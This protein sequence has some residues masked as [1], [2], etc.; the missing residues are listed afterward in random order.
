MSSPSNLYAEKVF[1]EQPIALWALDETVD[2]LSLVSDSSRDVNSWT[3]S[4][5]ATT[6]HST[7]DPASIPAEDLNGIPFFQSSYA[8]LSSVA[9]ANPLESLSVRLSDPI[10]VSSLNVTLNTFAISFYVK[11]LQSFTTG[12]EVG[13][14]LSD[15]PF[16]PASFEFKEKQIFSSPVAN[17]WSMYSATFSV[18]A[19][20][21]YQYVYPFISFVYLNQS[22][23]PSAPSSYDYVVNGFAAGQWAEQFSA[24][25]LGVTNTVDLSADAQLEFSA[26]AFIPGYQYG[27]GGNQAKYLVKN[28]KLLAK[29][30]SMP[31]VYGS[32][33]L[34]R[35]QPNQTEGKPSLLLPGMG[36][37]DNSGRYNPYTF[38]AW[39][40]IDSRS[41]QPRKILGPTSSDY[42]LYSDGPFLRFKIGEEIGSY[43]VGEWYRPMLVDIRIAVNSA[44]LLINGEEVLNIT[45]DTSDLV[46]EDLENGEDYWGVY[47][48][49]DVPVV[50]ID[51]PAFYPYVVPSLV[52][53]RRFG[54]GQ[55]VESPDGSNKSFGASTAFIDYSVADY[56]NNYQYPD[57]GKWEHGI[58]ENMDT[59]GLALSS[60]TV[61]LPDFI[62]QSTD[63]DSWY[64][65]QK[66][67]LTPY[68][69]FSENPGFIRFQTLDIDNQ[70]SKAVYAIFEIESFS[71]DPKI[72]LKLV[73]KVNGDSFS[74]ILLQDVLSYELTI[75]GQASVI[76]TKQGITLNEKVF[77]GASFVSLSNYFGSDVLSFFSNVQQ[78]MMFVAG[79]NT[80]TAQFDG[81]IYKVGLCTQRNVNKV[82]EFFEV[83]ELG[84]VDA[85]FYNMSVWSNVLDGGIPSSFTF[86]ELY[87]HIATY[88]LTASIDYGVYSLDVDCDSY[89]QD[90]LP[91]SYF[92]QYVKDSFG[93]E[94]YDLSFLQLNVDYPSTP[95]FKLSSYDTDEALVKTYVSF[96]LIESG[97]TKQLSE[98]SDVVTARRNNVV[99]PTAIRYG[100]GWI[101]TAFEVVDG[102]IIY[103]PNDVPMTSCAIVTHI[104]MKVR[105]AIKNKVGLRS[106]QYASQ[107]F[108]DTT[109]NPIGTK[110]NVPIFP[111]KR[112]SLFYDYKSRN[113]YRIYRGSTPYLYLTKKSGIEKVGDYDALIN[114]G[115]LIN[116]NEKAAE[117]YSLIATQMF[118]FFGQD[119]FP[120]G[121][122]KIFELESNYVS[123]KVFMQ[124][125]D[126]SNKRVRLYALNAKTGQFQTGLAF[127]INGKIVKTPTIN[128]NEWTALGIRFAEPLRFD[129][130]VGAIRFTG[131]MLVNNISYYESSSLQE[132]ERQSVRLWDAVSASSNSWAY[133]KNLL[134]QSATDYLWNDVLILSSTQYYGV[135]PSSIYK[136]YAGTNKIVAG[137]DSVLYVGGILGYKIT[138][139]LAWSSSIVKPL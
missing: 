131:P 1:A 133:W 72:I 93:E 25:S 134:T 121:E 47:A 118:M 139:G 97:A 31:M 10:P 116:V 113:P 28:N 127:Y 49:E 90:Y 34:T 76:S 78:L 37:L 87:D 24:E 70:P 38:E 50:E 51:C 80:Y 30:T 18:P 33:N 58:S 57:M 136:A 98:F 86:E 14:V 89:W 29:N 104:E 8:K 117:N 21:P 126:N 100:A 95:K 44:S 60:P 129:S 83:E 82:P 71:S 62:F 101:N 17:E 79:D 73:N 45:Y 9:G 68:F 42:G 114:R 67:H 26:E 32:E 59:T 4:P 54:F 41:D 61:S 84:Y 92:A 81:K 13:Y 20:S 137:D 77:V 120:T 124:P 64:S 15:S 12:V 115:F 107:A 36:M 56:T 123:I 122:T 132:V 27:L 102:T 112:Y 35:I 65:V 22:G 48:Y 40:R 138:N 119:S 85:G 5:Y 130:S 2:Y 69:T 16:D 52:A 53:K 88:T 63:Y 99:N 91:L 109:S 46:F 96:Q 110:F 111:Y 7:T 39:L 103:P 105:G 3:D 11:A 94:Y 106:L 55:A 43:F 75:R 108:N 125:I 74:V 66:T 6:S 23:S 135:N 19:S 128:L